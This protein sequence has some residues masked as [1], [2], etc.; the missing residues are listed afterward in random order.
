MGLRAWDKG[1]GTKGPSDMARDQGTWDQATWDQ[2]TRDQGTCDLIGD[3]GPGTN[4]KWD[5]FQ[6]ASKPSYNIKIRKTD[7]YTPPNPLFLMFWHYLT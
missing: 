5:T 6:G 1:H 3:L 7:L 2:E 4:G